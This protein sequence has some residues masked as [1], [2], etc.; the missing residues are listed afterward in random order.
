MNSSPMGRSKYNVCFM[1]MDFENNINYLTSLFN[2]GQWRRRK[3]TWE[4]IC[5]CQDVWQA[6]EP[7]FSL[8]WMEV[9]SL[10]PWPSFFSAN[11]WLLPFSNCIILSLDV[12][13]PSKPTLDG[14]RTIYF[15]DNFMS[16]SVWQLESRRMKSKILRNDSKFCGSF[17]N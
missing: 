6:H 14:V 3:C 7:A 17:L 11:Q 13:L 15:K 8:Q 1:N 4:L 9:P 5:S 16:D 2:C 12:L 10:P